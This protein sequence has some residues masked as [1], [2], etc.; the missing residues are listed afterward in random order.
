MLNSESYCYDVCKRI[1]HIS[2]R[3][4]KCDQ[5]DESELITGLWYDHSEDFKEPTKEKSCVVGMLLHD[6][7]G[8]KFV[9]QP[10]GAKWR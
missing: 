9:K 8:I 5:D 10:T 2:W 4:E 3:I 7:L 6:D 1:T